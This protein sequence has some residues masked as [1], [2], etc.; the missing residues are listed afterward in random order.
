[1]ANIN[2]CDTGVNWIFTNK[3]LQ[4]IRPAKIICLPFLK[5]LSINKP[6]RKNKINNSIGR[7]FLKPKDNVRVNQPHEL[8]ILEFEK[9]DLY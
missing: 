7:G 1:M 4:T 9:Y 2:C 3:K 8:A 5:R 6:I